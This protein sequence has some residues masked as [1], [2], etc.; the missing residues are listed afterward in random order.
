VQF[1][2]WE[3]IKKISPTQFEVHVHNFLPTSNLRILFILSPNQAQREIDDINAKIDPG[4]LS[5]V[6][7]SGLKL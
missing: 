6:E 7:D 3:P 2:M 4:M 1:C 5:C